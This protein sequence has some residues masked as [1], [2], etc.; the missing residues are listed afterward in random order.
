[1]PTILQGIYP[2]FTASDKQ[3]P[4]ILDNACGAVARIITSHQSVPLDQILPVLLNALPLR[5][6]YNENEPV[7]S[8]L[9]YLIATGNAVIA[10]HMPKLCSVFAQVIGPNA[11]GGV[12]PLL[13]QRLV[14]C[15]KQMRQQY[16]DQF[17]QL[18]NTLKPEEKQLLMAVMQ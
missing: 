8:A 2:C 5:D 9:M 16:G 18:L 12:T 1:M 15:L 17:L 11:K 4:A 7:F 3:D 14:Q 6:D 10:K 13:Q